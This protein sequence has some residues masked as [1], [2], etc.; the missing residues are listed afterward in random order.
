M[1]TS[2]IKLHWHTGLKWVFV[3]HLHILKGVGWG[4]DVKKRIFIF[5]PSFYSL[6]EKDYMLEISFS[7]FS[8]VITSWD[9]PEICFKI[10]TPIF[11]AYSRLDIL[12]DFYFSNRFAFL[13]YLHILMKFFP[14][15]LPHITDKLSTGMQTYHFFF[16]NITQATKADSL[17]P[18]TLRWRS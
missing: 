13:R 2:L 4:G 8:S 3:T 15:I 6:W 10:L 18:H 11:F 16:H 12:K 9:F 5:Y 17:L 7:P 1:C 14:L